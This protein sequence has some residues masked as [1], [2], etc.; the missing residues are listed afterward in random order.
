MKTLKNS[1]ETKAIKEHRCNFCNERIPKGGTYMKSTHIGDGGLYDWKTHKHC[2]ELA[3]IL[4]MY[5]NVEYWGVDQ[6]QFIES[7]RYEYKCI[8]DEMLRESMSDNFELISNQLEYVSFKHALGY[9][10][11]HHK[12]LI[13]ELNK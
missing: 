1:T 13:N 4:N 5:D 2:N 3:D 8:M 12:A 7:V 9:V 6:E 11:R 10:Y